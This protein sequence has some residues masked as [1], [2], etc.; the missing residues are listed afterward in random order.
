MVGACGG[1]AAA[2]ATLKLAIEVAVRSDCPE[3]VRVEAV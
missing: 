2:G 3:I 1:C